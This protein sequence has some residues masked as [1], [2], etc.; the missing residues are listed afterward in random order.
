MLH[1]FLYLLNF[2]FINILL[3]NNNLNISHYN[4][5]NYQINKF[6]KIVKINLIL[7]FEA[8]MIIS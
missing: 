4:K 1:C 3:I 6:T 2:E 8:N 5:N 7:K